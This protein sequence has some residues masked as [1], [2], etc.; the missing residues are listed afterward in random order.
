MM[1]MYSN[2]VRIAKKIA[3]GT[4]ISGLI[5]LAAFY[6][7]Y[8]TSYAYGG[9]FFGLGIAAIAITILTSALIAASR[10]NHDSKQ[11]STTIIWNAI[12]LIVLAIF[13]LIG[14]NL[15]NSAKIVVKNNLDSEIKNIFITG[16]QNFEVQT[17]AANSSKS[18]LVNYANNNVE[19]CEIGIR[20]TTQNSMEDEILIASVK[21]L[22]GE[23]VIYEIN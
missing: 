2:N 6:F 4:I 22:Q 5:F 8:N 9:A 18:I 16:C 21:P 12:T 20:Y 15:L 17:I 13:T 11:K 23:K 19:N 7:T 1:H 10:Q 3:I 14:Y